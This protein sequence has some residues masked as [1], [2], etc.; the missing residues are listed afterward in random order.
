M[1]TFILLVL[2]FLFVFFVS[3]VNNKLET[4]S[5]LQW[6]VPPL[7]TPYRF[8]TFSTLLLA[9]R[10]LSTIQNFLTSNP[11]K[12]LPT[13]TPTSAHT[14]FSKL[15]RLSGGA[16]RSFMNNLRS[17]Q[18]SDSSLRSISYSLFTTTKELTT[19]ISKLS[20]SLLRAPT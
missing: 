11:P 10:V 12:T 17:E 18:C 3:W 6:P 2:S 13:P 5:H 1:S 9:R 16:E 14:F 20:T 15:P 19:T 7:K 8:S 4:G